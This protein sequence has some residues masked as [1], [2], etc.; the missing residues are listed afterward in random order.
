MITMGLGS[1]LRAAGKN[2]VSRRAK[3]KGKDDP[4][5]VDAVDAGSTAG[6]TASTAQSKRA[7]RRAKRAKRAERAKQA[8]R[9]EREARTHRKHSPT[10]ALDDGLA[11]LRGRL[12]FSNDDIG[13]MT[14]QLP[15][16][17]A[18]NDTEKHPRVIFYSPDVDGQADPGEIV[19]IFAPTPGEA[20]ERALLVVGRSRYRGI[21]GLLISPNDKHANDDNWIDI[22]S[23]QWDREGRRS[24]VRLDKLIQVPEHALRRE[25]MLFPRGRFERVA[26]ALR[27]DYGWS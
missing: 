21:L 18:V 17:V 2:L 15:A 13:A 11:A 9:S 12:G 19:W 24:W 4:D 1:R 27:N 26:A 22:G 20:Q 8:E 5:T 23:G 6:T 10:S 16:P 3:R 14:K 25:G 7:Q